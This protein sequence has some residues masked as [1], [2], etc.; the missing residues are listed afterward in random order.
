MA[1]LNQRFAE[2]MQ[3]KILYENGRSAQ[4]GRSHL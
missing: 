3:M 1:W 2:G 4:N